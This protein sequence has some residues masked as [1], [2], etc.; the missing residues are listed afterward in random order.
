MGDRRP[1]IAGNWKMYK[2]GKEA[3]EF[4]DDLN[5]LIAGVMDV[6]IVV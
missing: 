1:V 6:E 4:I 3:V 5:E 2:T